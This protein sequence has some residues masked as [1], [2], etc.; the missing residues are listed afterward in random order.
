VRSE[1]LADF[2]RTHPRILLNVQCDLTLNL[3]ERF[4]N[5]AFAL[6]LVKVSRPGRDYWVNCST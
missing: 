1:L 2:A 6:V 5:Q 3:I 4:E